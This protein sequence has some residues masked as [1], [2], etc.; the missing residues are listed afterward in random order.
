MSGLKYVG[1]SIIVASF[2]LWLTSVWLAFVAD[3][4]SEDVAVSTYGCAPDFNTGPEC[5]RRTADFSS[6]LALWGVAVMVMV[7]GL[8]LY[9][10]G[11]GRIP[12]RLVPQG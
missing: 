1:A 4:V 3:P 9:V 12:R 6:G 8:V 2:L 7:F 11:G 5:A 10:R